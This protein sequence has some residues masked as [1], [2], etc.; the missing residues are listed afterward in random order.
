MT[1]GWLTSALQESWKFGADRGRYEPMMR[2]S[3]LKFK[4]IQRWFTS[5]T[6]IW[7][8]EV[9][10]FQSQ[11]NF[12]YCMKSRRLLVPISPFYIAEANNMNLS[13]TV[14]TRI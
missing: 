14:Y 12:E 9:P 3:L 13:E 4:M 6:K 2:L 5:E 7:N 1:H 8:F 10:H 11:N